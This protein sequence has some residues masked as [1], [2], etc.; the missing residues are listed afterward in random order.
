MAMAARLLPL[1]SAL[2]LSLLPPLASARRV[3]CL[4]GLGGS[5]F[6]FLNMHLKPLRGAAAASYKDWRPVAWEFDAVDS[7][8]ASGG[9]WEYAPAGGKSTTAEEL[10]GLEESLQFVEREIVEGERSTR[11]LCCS[12]VLCCA[13]CCSASSTSLLSS[14]FSPLSSLFRSSLLRLW[15]VGCRPR[16]AAAAALDSSPLLSSLHRT[17]SL[18]PLSPTGDYCGVFGFSQGAMLA[19][20]IAARASLGEGPCTN[21]R[22]A[23]CCGAALPKPQ[24]PLFKRLRDAPKG[25]KRAMPTLHCLSK[26]DDDQPPAMGEALANSFE[27]AEVLWHDLGHRLPPAEMY[28]EVVAFMDRAGPDL[29]RST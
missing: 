24:A 2:L 7:P 27:G 15:A 13:L 21:L 18:A 29:K 14:L 16:A 23:V 1:L 19:S 3:L 17:T 26:S 11:L 25:G 5:A 6:P 20:I 10:V 12:A 4:H 9:W 8:R 28:K 22:F